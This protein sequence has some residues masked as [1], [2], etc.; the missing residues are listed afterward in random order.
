MADSVGVREKLPELLKAVFPGADAGSNNGCYVNLGL[1]LTLRRGFVGRSASSIVA[2][3][4]LLA[5][6]LEF[7]DDAG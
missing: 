6:A 7:F 3:P 2:R 5:F 4:L 1:R